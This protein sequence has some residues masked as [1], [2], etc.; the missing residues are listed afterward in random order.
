MFTKLANYLEEG[1]AIRQKVISALTYPI[2]LIGFSIIVIVSLLA[3]VL[4]NVVNQFIKAGADLPLITKILLA[5]SNNIG[6]ILIL[7]S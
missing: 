3:F 1:A 6:I 2:I 7:A 4:P 5:I